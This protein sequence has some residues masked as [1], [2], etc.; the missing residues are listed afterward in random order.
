[1]TPASLRDPYHGFNFRVEIDGIVSG[2][3]SEVS[4]LE[5]EVEVVEHRE[6]DEPGPLRKSPGLTKYPNITLKRG[7]VGS[8]ELWTWIAQ[9][10][11]GRPERKDGAVI[12][13]DDAHQ[14]VARWVFS[15]G[16]PCKWTGPSLQASANEVAL[17]T[18]EI[19]HE[20]L[21]LETPS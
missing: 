19:A 6:G 13:F 16:W 5:I 4:G 1:M 2:S 11:N 21:E 12:L 15:R 8:N 3:F 10:K 18:L 9:A 7:F 20:G 14:E 17:E